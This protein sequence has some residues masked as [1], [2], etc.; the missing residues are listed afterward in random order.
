MKLLFLTHPY[1]NYVPDLLL[2][3]LR[4]LVGPTVVDYPRKDCVYDGVLG[5]GVCPPISSAPVG[6]HRTAGRSIARTSA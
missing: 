1:P 4:K 3:G 5:L 2:H 6:F